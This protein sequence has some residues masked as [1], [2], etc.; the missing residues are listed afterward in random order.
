LYKVN[1]IET[2]SQNEANVSQHDVKHNQRLPNKVSHH[3]SNP[4]NH[5]PSHQVIGRLDG[6]LRQLVE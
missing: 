2:V 4:I 1:E 6:H 5:L 3:Q